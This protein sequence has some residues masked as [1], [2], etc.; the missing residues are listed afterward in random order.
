VSNETIVLQMENLFVNVSGERITAFPET[1]TIASVE[2][3]APTSTVV[4]GL[5]KTGLHVINGSDI[6]TFTLNVAPMSGDDEYLAR[7]IRL[8]RTTGRILGV[9]A[10]YEGTKYVSGS[11]SITTEPTRVFNADGV[12]FNAYP[13]AGVFTIADVRKFTNPGVLTADEIKGN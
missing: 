4:G 5:H 9:S 6:Y 13:L 11:C 2:K 8:I 7:A 10:T 3:G 12:E 1:G